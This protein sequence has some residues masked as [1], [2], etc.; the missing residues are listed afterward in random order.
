M[1]SEASGKGK[2]DGIISIIIM[3]NRNGRGAYG[4]V[5]YKCNL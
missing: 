2:E 1:R 3:G 4:V 5:S